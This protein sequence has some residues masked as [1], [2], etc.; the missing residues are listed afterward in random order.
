MPTDLAAHINYIHFNPIKH[1]L[2]TKLSDW[3]WSSYNDYLSAG[4]YDAY[5][6][7]AQKVR[8][9]IKQD[10][11]R[12]FEKFDV[13]LSPTAPTPA[14]RLGEKSGDPLTMYLSD[15]CTVPINLAGIPA[16]SIPAGFVDGLPVGLQLMGKH[17]DEGTLYRVAYTFEQNTSFHT[18]KP[19]LV[20]G[21]AR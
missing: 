13:L 2:V 15:V 10:F 3:H 1:G 5:Y 21:G 4:Y 11:D 16:L 17:F 19:S 7:K 6:V 12:A 20:R 9:L 14:F 8:T 18:V